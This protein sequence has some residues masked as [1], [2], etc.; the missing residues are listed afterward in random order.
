MIMEVKTDQ[1]REKILSQKRVNQFSFRELRDGTSVLRDSHP[2]I[3][4]PRRKSKKGLIWG[5]LHLDLQGMATA[6]HN[7]KD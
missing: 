5:S 3:T 7:H 1:K 4:V 6:R 2:P